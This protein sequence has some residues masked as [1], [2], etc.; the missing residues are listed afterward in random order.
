VSS[1]ASVNSTT[2]RLCTKK[3]ELE[4]KL[5]G[6]QTKRIHVVWEKSSAELMNRH[7]GEKT[8]NLEKENEG[9]SYQLVEVKETISQMHLDV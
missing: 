1:G 9:L 3:T 7:L 8:S 5:E 2:S 4:N 6:L